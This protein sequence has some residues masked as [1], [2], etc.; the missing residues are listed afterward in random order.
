MNETDNVVFSPGRSDFLPNSASS[1]ARS[2]A[3]LI[4]SCEPF[5]GKSAVVLGL[6]RQWLQ[7]GLAVRDSLIARGLPGERLF[8]GAPKVRGT[9]E[10]E[11]PW[12]PRVSLTLDAP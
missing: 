10:E 6:A 3:L 9:A 8:L 11:G 5:S 1:H 7:R 4:G 12:T 2:S